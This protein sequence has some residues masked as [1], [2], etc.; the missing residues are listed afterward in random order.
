MPPPHDPTSGLE[1]FTKT[2]WPYIAAALL[3]LQYIYTRDIT[4]TKLDKDEAKKEVVEMDK[5]QEELAAKVLT[6]DGRLSRMES[7]NTKQD[8]QIE[9]LSTRQNELEKTIILSDGIRRR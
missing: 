9:K 3:L 1:R 7:D 6:I 8:G 4:Q 5:K 2:F